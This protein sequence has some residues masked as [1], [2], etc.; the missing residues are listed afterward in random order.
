MEQKGNVDFRA[1]HVQEDGVSEDSLPLLPF[2]QLEGSRLLQPQFRE[3]YSPSC[4]SWQNVGSCMF[5]LFQ[6]ISHSLV[7]SQT[8]L[9]LNR[10]K[11]W[12]DLKKAR[13][14]ALKVSTSSYTHIFCAFFCQF[15]SYSPST[16]SY[17]QKHTYNHVLRTVFTLTSHFL[18]FVPVHQLQYIIL[19]IG[20]FKTKN[21]NFN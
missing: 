19:N 4:L 1:P 16:T 13:K 21:G 2:A 11:P 3:L 5:Q 9:T 7:Q 12:F 14:I 8:A 6:K 15:H 18:A 17:T 10:S 20:G